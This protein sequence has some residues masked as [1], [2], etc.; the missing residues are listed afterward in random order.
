MTARTR[1]RRT[2]GRQL[3]SMQ[4]V[5][6]WIRNL[7]SALAGAAYAAPVFVGAACEYAAV[8]IAL[9]PGRTV[10]APREAAARERRGPP[11]FC[12]VL[13]GSG[14]SQQRFFDKSSTPGWRLC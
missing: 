1:L 11:G 4:V 10:L 3:W 6:D 2:A 8:D 14:R 13:P 9:T 5:R 12:A 7:S